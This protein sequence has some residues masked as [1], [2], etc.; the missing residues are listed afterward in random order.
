MNC[1]QRWTLLRLAPVRSQERTCRDRYDRIV[2][3]VHH[4]G[5]AH[6]RSHGESEMSDLVNEL[7][8]RDWHFQRFGPERLGGAPQL[9]QEGAG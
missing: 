1:L 3:L 8:T 5:F 7:A 2:V 9:Y 4:R 6:P